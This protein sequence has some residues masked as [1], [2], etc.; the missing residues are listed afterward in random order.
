MSPN[1]ELNP[2]RSLP[3]ITVQLP[4]ASAAAA[5]GASAAASNQS[6]TGALSGSIGSREAEPT[7]FFHAYARGLNQSSFSSAA[8]TRRPSVNFNHLSAT[9]SDDRD[10]TRP[11]PSSS[12]SSSSSGAANGYHWYGSVVTV[13]ERLYFLS[14][15]HGSDWVEDEE[16]HTDWGESSYFLSHTGPPGAS[17]MGSGSVSGVKRGSEVFPSFGVGAGMGSGFV[18]RE[19]SGVWAGVGGVGGGLGGGLG[20]PDPLALTLPADDKRLGYRSLSMRSVST[21]LTV[22]SEDFSSVRSCASSSVPSA[23]LE[24]EGERQGSNATASTL[25]AEGPYSAEMAVSGVGIKRVSPHTPKKTSGLSQS[26]RLS[27]YTGS[28]LGHSSPSSPVATM[29]KT[30]SSG[31]LGPSFGPNATLAPSPSW[32]L[33]ERDRGSNR[34]SISG[35]S[36]LLRMQSMGATMGNIMGHNGG[37]NMGNGGHNGGMGHNMVHNMGGGM[38]HNVS[39]VS[40]ALSTG[41]LNPNPTAGGVDVRAMI[42]EAKRR[43]DQRLNTDHQYLHRL[44]FACVRVG[45]SGFVWLSNVSGKVSAVSDIDTSQCTYEQY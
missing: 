17:G 38:G 13:V 37:H 4:S 39:H 44:A 21:P 20:P 10:A 27:Q 41:H 25:D 11:P 29:G 5:A 36:G 40:S 14:V 1:L 18:T 33:R 45:P 24:A 9:P 22:V 12:S 42:G 6:T 16:Q 3:Y 2:F 32:R 8:S 31:L 23:P 35:I 28:Q 15:P 7:N 26:L 43:S 19:G 30:P 34:N